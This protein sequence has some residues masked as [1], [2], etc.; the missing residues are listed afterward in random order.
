[1]WVG[2]MKKGI[3]L[4]PNCSEIVC[5][6]PTLG[7]MKIAKKMMKEII[8][9]DI[10]DKTKNSLVDIVNEWSHEDI[11]NVGTDSYPNGAIESFLDK[12]DALKKQ[13]SDYKDMPDLR[14]VDNNG[15]GGHFEYVEASWKLAKLAAFGK[16]TKDEAIKFDEGMWSDEQKLIDVCQECLNK[17]ADIKCSEYVKRMVGECKGKYTE[18]KIDSLDKMEKEMLH[19]T[20]P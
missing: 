1:M 10:K 19:A 3:L 4:N 17:E 15:G 6:L 16:F 9:S 14:Y 7:S 12:A 8:A 20:K 5:S 13:I 2:S 18:K 11:Y